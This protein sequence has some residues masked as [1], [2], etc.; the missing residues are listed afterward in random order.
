MDKKS[1]VRDM[2]AHCK[3]HDDID[4]VPFIDIYIDGEKFIQFGWAGELI[5]VSDDYKEDLEKYLE[6]K[7]QEVSQNTMSNWEVGKDWS[8]E[9]V[10]TILS[11]MLK[12][13][14]KDTYD[15]SNMIERSCPE[16]GTYS[17]E[18]MDS[19]EN[20]ESIEWNED[21][22][23]DKIKE[24]YREIKEKD[25]SVEGVLQPMPICYFSVDDDQLKY[26]F[27]PAVHSLNSSVNSEREQFRSIIK[28]YPNINIVDETSGHI[29]ATNMSDWSPE[30]SLEVTKRVLNEIF[31]VRIG[32]ISAVEIKGDPDM[33]KTWRDI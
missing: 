6:N 29:S 9:T 33:R 24:L 25:K 1:Q 14:S 31:E 7:C 10:E 18:D 32:D 5:I 11:E 22:K 8:P 23:E 12:T 30:S 4:V 20:S 3:D 19:S 28:D 16:Y 17:L 13:I 2:L 15:I 21:M 27:A 26:D